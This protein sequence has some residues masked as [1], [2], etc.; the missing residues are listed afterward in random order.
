MARITVLRTRCLQFRLTGMNHNVRTHGLVI[1]WAA[2]YDL[3]AWIFTGGRERQFRERMID[4]AHLQPGEAVLDIGCGTGTLAL[5][6]AERVGGMGS[7]QAID[8]SPSMIVRARRKAATRPVQPRFEVAVVEKLPFPDRHFDV[9]LSTLM[10][11]HLPRPTR[12]QCFGEVLRVLKPSGRLLAVDFGRPQHRGLLSHLHRHGHVAF[13]DVAK[14]L[15]AA[16]MVVI[17][18][19]PVGMRD[20]QFV[21][22]DKPV[23]A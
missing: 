14:M 21:R 6:A 2:R 15:E 17:A 20:L 11:H 1:D 18:S 19:G 13:E 7:V 9:V 22:A 23:N 10:L 12:Q 8:A 3:L 5:L 16:G 4:L